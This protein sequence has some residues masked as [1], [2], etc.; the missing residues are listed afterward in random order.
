ML[1]PDNALAHLRMF[2]GPAADE[3]LEMCQ[4]IVEGNGS[5]RLMRGVSAPPAELGYNPCG[6]GESILSMRIFLKLGLALQVFVD[7]F[8]HFDFFS[9]KSKA[10]RKY[11]L[12]IASLNQLN[13]DSCRFRRDGHQLHQS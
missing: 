9:R 3:N 8:E 4:A 11:I 6:P 12:T 5:W 10:C 1:L 2:E 7:G 13:D